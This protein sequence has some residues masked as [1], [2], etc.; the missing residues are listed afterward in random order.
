MHMPSPLH[1]G[2]AD[3]V[4][5]VHLL[6]H[7]QAVCCPL[8][9]STVNHSSCS[10]ARQRL[11]IRVAAAHLSPGSAAQGYDTI[12]L[13]AWAVVQLSGVLDQVSRRCCGKGKQHNT[14]GITACILDSRVAITERRDESV[15]ILF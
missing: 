7:N 13:F 12:M 11:H 9:R 3:C 4:H 2:R 15:A 5:Q 6:Q 8:H 10:S 1:S 14:E